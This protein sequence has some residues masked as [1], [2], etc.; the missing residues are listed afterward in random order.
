MPLQGAVFGPL[1]MTGRLSSGVGENELNKNGVQVADDQRVVLFDKGSYELTISARTFAN[2]ADTPN[3]FGDAGVY[4]RAP[5]GIGQAGIFG[6]GIGLVHEF[7]TFKSSFTF[8]Q[9]GW[10]LRMFSPATLA[11]NSLEFVTTCYVRQLL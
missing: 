9:K 2:Y 1:D 6:V 8:S 4:L 7:Q 5:D 3:T 11:G 10:E